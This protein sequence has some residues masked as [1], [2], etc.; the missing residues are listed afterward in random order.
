MVK[1]KVV[2]ELSERTTTVIGRSGSSTPWLAAA[3][4]SSFHVG[5]LAEEDVRV[6]VA[7]QLDLRYAR[8]VVGQHDLARSH[9]QEHRALLYLSH[10]VVGHRRVAGGEVHDPVDE[11]LDARA[12]ALGLIVDGHAI[13][14]LAEVLEPGRV[15]RKG[16]AGTRSGEPHL[17][18]RGRR[19][20]DRGR[21]RRADD[22]KSH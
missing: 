6:D 3:I 15:E 2:P 11:I 16:K 9:R 19:Q 1:L 14:L 17:G 12:A 4:R 5:D 7:R 13:R 18:K 8:Q 20:N 22:G 21:D 10:L